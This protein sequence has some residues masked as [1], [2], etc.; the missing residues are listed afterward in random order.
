MTHE[1]INKQTKQQQL[2]RE[3]KQ[4]R[5]SGVCSEGAALDR[6]IREG[7]SG[8]VTSQV[9]LNVKKR[10]LHGNLHEGV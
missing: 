1:Y 6:V 8:E 9:T 10:P 7:L 3:L 4:G 2:C 5:E